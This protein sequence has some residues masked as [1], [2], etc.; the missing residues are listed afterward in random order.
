MPSPKIALLG[1]VLE[2]NRSSP[3]ATRENFESFYVFEG[4]ALLADARSASPTQ[5]LNM[6]RS[7]SGGGSAAGGAGSTAAAGGGVA[8]MAG[9]A[10]VKRFPITNERSFSSV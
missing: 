10:V 1:V 4:D 7:Y 5:V 2:S 3:V 6:Y 8:T 9:S